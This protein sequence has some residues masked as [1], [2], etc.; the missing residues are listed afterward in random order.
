MKSQFE[1]KMKSQFEKMKSQ[2]EEKMKS[3]FEEMK[4]QLQKQ[5]EEIDRLSSRE[6]KRKSFSFGI[7]GSFQIPKLF[8]R[9]TLLIL[10][11]LR[12]LSER[13]LLEKFNLSGPKTHRY[14]L[15]NGMREYLP[16]LVEQIIQDHIV[17]VLN[18]E[19]QEEREK[20]LK[21]YIDQKSKKIDGLTIGEL[22]TLRNGLRT[23]DPLVYHRYFQRTNEAYLMKKVFLK[24][25]KDEIAE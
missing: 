10:L 8:F 4:S 16:D 13:E 2:F 23:L 24:Q 12:D 7:S 9:G 20:R 15:I 5:Q 11:L 21:E 17:P 19:T 3:Q 6:K 18:S 25:E 14:V 22:S 1:E